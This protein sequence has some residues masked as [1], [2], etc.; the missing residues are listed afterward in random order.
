MKNSVIIIALLLIVTCNISGTN[1]YTLA[2][3]KKDITNIDTVK[4]TPKKT[5][6]LKDWKETKKENKDKTIGKTKDG[7]T[8]YEGP[9]G[10]RYYI[11]EK[12]KKVYIKK[13]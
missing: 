7:K 5:I 1:F 12:G 2:Q 10:G 4:T 8:I 3:D 9:R 11:S 13:N 6:V